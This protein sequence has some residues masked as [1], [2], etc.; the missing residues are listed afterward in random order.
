MLDAWGGVSAAASLLSNRLLLT[1]QFAQILTAQSKVQVTIP[2][3]SLFR[4]VA[5]IKLLF[6]LVLLIDGHH[7]VHLYLHP[8]ITAHRGALGTRRNRQGALEA[9]RPP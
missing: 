3:R 1:T 8:S 7:F 9:L 5:T 2:R 6:Y 4:F